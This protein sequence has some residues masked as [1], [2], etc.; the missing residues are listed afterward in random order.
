MKVRLTM[1]KIKT[2]K[3]NGISVGHENVDV[4]QRECTERITKKF[5][6]GYVTHVFVYSL[7]AGLITSVGVMRE[8]NGLSYG[9]NSKPLLWNTLTSDLCDDFVAVVY[10]KLMPAFLLSE[11][12]NGQANCQEE[13]GVTCEDIRRP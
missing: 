13:G 4:W 2:I 12:V 6:V 9:L 1:A 8:S 10:D 3:L 11:K 5:G 7:K